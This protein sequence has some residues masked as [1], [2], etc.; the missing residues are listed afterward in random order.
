M[1]L[2][3]NKLNELVGTMEQ[4]VSKGV[5]FAKR[6]KDRRIRATLRAMRREQETP[7]QFKDIWFCFKQWLT[8]RLSKA[9]RSF[10]S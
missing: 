4:V 1:E 8:N 3:H 10:T 6:N 9:K 5:P 2:T 7:L